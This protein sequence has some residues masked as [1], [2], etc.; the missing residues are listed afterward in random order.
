MGSATSSPGATPTGVR[1]V[2]GQVPDGGLGVAPNGES[3]CAP[4][5]DRGRTWSYLVSMSDGPLLRRVDCLASPVPDL[6]RALAFYTTVG[7]ELVW[8]TATSAGL[9]L[10]D[11]GAELVLQT[12]RPDPETDLTVDSVEP[13]VDRFVGAGGSVIIA[14]FDIAIGRSA[15]VAEPW[16]NRLVL[17]DNSKGVFVTNEGGA[18]TGV[19]RPDVIPGVARPLLTAAPL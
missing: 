8:R 19:E 13:A 10:P 7:H 14:P 18:V 4:P 12:E 9:S 16:D 1:S 6:D 11:C 15:V 2:T 3:V 5:W 17:V